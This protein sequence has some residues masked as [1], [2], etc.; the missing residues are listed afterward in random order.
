MFV[1][2]LLKMHSILLVNNV[3]AKCE[4]DWFYSCMMYTDVASKRCM[5]TKDVEQC[6]LC[7]SGKRWNSTRYSLY[8]LLHGY[9]TQHDH[10]IL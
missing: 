8:C 6:S 5:N 9:L 1:V 3:E 4:W 2:L 10:E 7:T